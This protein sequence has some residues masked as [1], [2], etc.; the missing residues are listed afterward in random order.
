LLIIVPRMTL[1]GRHKRIFPACRRKYYATAI[2][3]EN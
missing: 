1:L 3:H 2:I